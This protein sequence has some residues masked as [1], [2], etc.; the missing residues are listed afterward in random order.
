MS[1]EGIGRETIEFLGKINKYF[2]NN[3]INGYVFLIDE[4]LNEKKKSMDFIVINDEHKDI[5]LRLA[6]KLGDFAP[7]V[8]PFKLK[9]DR[10]YCKIY[11]GNSKTS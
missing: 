5:I 1:L 4:S 6:N 7:C 9:E 11:P 8:Y 10:I 2:T 3:N